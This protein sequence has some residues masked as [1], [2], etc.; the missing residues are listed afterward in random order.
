MKKVFNKKIVLVI[1]IV[2]VIAGLALYFMLGTDN[3]SVSKE[4]KYE[5]YVIY[6]GH[7]GSLEKYDSSMTV[8]GHTPS[9]NAYYITGKISTKEDKEFSVI[10][11][12]LYD[13]DDKIIGTAVAGLNE[14]KKNQKYDFKAIALVD[15]KDLSK[16]EYYDLKSVELG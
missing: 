10:T 9:E 14:L 8:D 5:D 12:N 3:D 4:L 15:A 1:L 16:I 2:L 11:F 6:E 13:K 7:K